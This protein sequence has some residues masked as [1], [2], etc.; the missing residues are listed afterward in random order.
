MPTGSITITP[1]KIMADG[2]KVSNTKLNQ[3]FRPVGQ[4]DANSIGERELIPADVTAVAG[5][6]GLNLIINGDFLYWPVSEDTNSSSPATLTGR[7][8][9]REITDGVLNSTTT[10]T[11]ATAAF[12]NADVAQAV[13]GPGIPVGTR[14]NSVTNSTTIVLSAAA[15]VTGGSRHLFI[16]DT[17]QYGHAARWVIANDANRTAT[18]L[19]FTPG[20]TAVPDNP[21]VYL[22]WHQSAVMSSVI[23]PAYFG[24]RNSNVS[25]FSQRL[26][27]WT[28]WVRADSNLTVT[29]AIRQ[30]FGDFTLGASA[31][32]RVAGTPVPLLA[33]IW[34]KIKTTWTPPSV[35]GKTFGVSGSRPTQQAP[36]IEFRIEVPL[37]T[38]FDIDF[39]HSQ[40]IDGDVELPW[41]VRPFVV[42]YLSALRFRQQVGIMLSDNLATHGNPSVNLP[43]AMV[44][45]V[46][47][48]QITL[49][50]SSGTG[51]AVAGDSGL[52]NHI[53]QTDPHSAV[54]QAV[55]LVDQELHA[56]Q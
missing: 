37:T 5:T 52:R 23:N 48:G 40:L 53:I 19:A 41:D 35:S 34:T 36:F 9:A 8:N 6:R 4:V 46:N 12:T 44:A 10:V 2:E 29:P 31:D 32:V 51:G 27:L 16:G 15:T 11:S 22:R 1:G 21:N 56:P 42:D 33:G 55:I 47:L 17:H 20:Q 7:V 13:I 50:P 45:P 18:R 28:I 30:S 24:H 54:A 43:I 25:G 14:I 49:T 39:A 38:I 3:G 26:L